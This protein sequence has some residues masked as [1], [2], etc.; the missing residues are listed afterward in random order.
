MSVETFL[1]WGNCNG[2]QIVWGGLE[3][4]AAATA[5]AGSMEEQQWAGFSQTTKT[6]KGF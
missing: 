4:I 5:E 6:L 2:T 1:L 3:N